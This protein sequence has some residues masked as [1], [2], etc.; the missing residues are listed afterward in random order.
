M[1]APG[2]ILMPAVDIVRSADIPHAARFSFGHFIG[3][4]IWLAVA[5][6]FAWF[7]SQMHV[8]QPLWSST[9]FCALYFALIA[10]LPL[11][12]TIQ[13]PARETCIRP[14]IAGLIYGV[15]N[16]SAFPVA[17]CVL[18]SLI[19]VFGSSNPSFS[20]LLEALV[21]LLIGAVSIQGATFLPVYMMK[22]GWVKSELLNILGSV[23]LYVTLL[24]AVG[25]GWLHM[26]T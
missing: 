21:V 8:Y 19:G 23:P 11:N 10:I 16:F 9:P 3:Y 26:R 2:S 20:R 15:K 1:V 4:I 17:V 18:A 25:I 22:R 5:V 13:I 7:G 12:K 24:A 14:L 6:P